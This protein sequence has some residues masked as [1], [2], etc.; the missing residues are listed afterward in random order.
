MERKGQKREVIYMPWFIVLAQNVKKKE[1]AD[2][3]FVNLHSSMGPSP[4]L[5]G[6]EWNV[7][8]N[9]ESLENNEL[10]RVVLFHLY[11]LWTI[12]NEGKGN[13]SICLEVMSDWLVPIPIG[14]LH[15]YFL[16][17]FIFYDMTT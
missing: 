1:L 17:H 15:F 2:F 14:Q 7:E 6:I 10:N 4:N 9:D 13:L 3:H 5:K 8:S 12:G 16:S 11:F